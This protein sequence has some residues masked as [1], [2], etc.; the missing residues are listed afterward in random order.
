MYDKK[1]LK[2]FFD[3]FRPL[4]Q[5]DM[6]VLRSNIKP[7]QNVLEYGC[8]RMPYRKY[9][10]SIGARYKSADVEKSKGVDYKITSD[11]I[12]PDCN[13]TFDVVLVMDV[14]QHIECPEKNIR[15][16]TP[17]LAPNGILVV[18]T[19]FIFAE[20]D[21]EDF[22]RWSRSG[23]KGLFGRSG[24]ETVSQVDRGGLCLS[25]TFLLLSTLSKAIIGQRKGWRLD[26]PGLRAF[27]LIFAEC[28]FLP[29]LWISLFVDQLKSGKV[30][31]LGSI[32]IFRK[33]T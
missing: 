28:I 15:N 18:S 29:L 32:T 2:S 33:V 11:G 24:F 17:Y 7:G 16:L 31:Y 4:R 10:T 30:A 8:G 25:I 27:L 9:I 14:L 6:A 20:C 21:F 1:Y 22:H 19:P 26:L 12:L 13:Q 5:I 3:R 23:V